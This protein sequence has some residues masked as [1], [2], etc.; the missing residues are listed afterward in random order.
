MQVSLLLDFELQGKLMALAPELQEA[1]NQL[2]L[3]VSTAIDS[4]ET[5]EKIDINT[6][7]YATVSFPLFVVSGSKEVKLIKETVQRFCNERGF[8][9]NPRISETANELE[10]VI[11]KSNLKMH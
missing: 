11:R 5:A 7:Y 8:F 1:I 2:S 6:D 10:F 3:D 4:I 9:S